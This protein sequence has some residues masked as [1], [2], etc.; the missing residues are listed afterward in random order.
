[1]EGAD[2][3]LALLGVDPGLAADRRIDLGQQGGRH[4]HDADSAPQDAGGEAGQVSHHAAAEGDDAV[5]ALHPELEQPLR[6]RSEHGKALARL[7]GLDHHL[8]EQE[9]LLSEAR[10]EHG[11]MQRCHIGVG[12]HRVRAPLSV[13][14]IRRPDEA[15]RSSPMTMA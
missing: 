1:M 11:K 9:P 13:A 7:A 10:L 3:I 5:A 8:A 15:S 2:Q 12:H 6:E 14:A 4:L